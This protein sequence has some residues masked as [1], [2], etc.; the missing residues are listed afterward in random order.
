[1]FG[2]AKLSFAQPKECQTVFGFAKLGFARVA[3]R[4]FAK[5]FG[6]PNY[7]W[8]RAGASAVPRSNDF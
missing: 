5:T 8:Q 4:C 3:K 1:M 7:V 6:M 2:F